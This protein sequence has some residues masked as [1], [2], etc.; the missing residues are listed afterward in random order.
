[1]YSFN[2]KLTGTGISTGIPFLAYAFMISVN[3]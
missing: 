1:M 3:N 2:N